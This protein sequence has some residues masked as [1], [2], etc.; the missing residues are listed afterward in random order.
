MP[1][2]ATP[3]LLVPFGQQQQPQQQAQPLPTRP[4]A[5][6]RSPT[7]SRTL[8]RRRRCLG[9][10]DGLTGLSSLTGLAG[11]TQQQVGVLGGGGMFGATQGGALTQPG[12]AGTLS[13]VLYDGDGGR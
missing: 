3:S 9:L 12:G 8:Q 11:L 5:P 2:R 1:R 6:P 7:T 10:D 4:M 13:Q